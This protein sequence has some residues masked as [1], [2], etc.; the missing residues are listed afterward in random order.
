MIL[1]YYNITLK[2][3]FLFPW[4]CTFNDRQKHCVLIYLG[5]RLLLVFKYKK[6]FVSCVICIIFCFLYFSNAV[7]Y[8]SK[9]SHADLSFCLY[10]AA[11]M[12]SSISYFPVVVLRKN[13][14][15]VFLKGLWSQMTWSYLF[16]LQKKSLM[17]SC[18]VSICVP[19]YVSCPCGLMVHLLRF[20]SFFFHKFT[21][22]VIC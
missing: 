19:L 7:Q 10:S 4:L 18:P 6:L 16:I 13:W 9:A 1:N 14:I 17:C 8:L 15:D 22:F 11:I 2:K 3:N 20:L 21:K 12:W 5:L